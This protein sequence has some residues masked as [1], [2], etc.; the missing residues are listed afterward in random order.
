[1]P[2]STLIRG[3][4]YGREVSLGIDRTHLERVGFESEITCQ[5][6]NILIG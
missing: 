6:G 2:T 4:T 5:V 3:F 1:M